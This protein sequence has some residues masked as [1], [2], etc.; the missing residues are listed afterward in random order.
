MHYCTWMQVHCFNLLGGHIKLSAQCPNV[1]MW[2]IARYHNTR[3]CDPRLKAGHG[4]IVYFFFLFLHPYKQRGWRYPPSHQDIVIL[5]LSEYTDWQMFSQHVP[6]TKVTQND[7]LLLSRDSHSVIK[8][9]T[10]PGEPAEFKFIYNQLQHAK[11]EVHYRFRGPSRKSVTNY[12]P[13]INCTSVN[14]SA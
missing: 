10:F 7:W 5:Q 6:S 1:Y 11:G 8:I 2:R 13:E 9:C 12:C 4:P 14:L 3:E